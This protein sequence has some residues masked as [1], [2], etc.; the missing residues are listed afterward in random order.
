MANDL[1]ER[2]HLYDAFISYAHEDRATAIWLQDYLSNTWVPGK[3]RRRI[4]LDTSHLTATGTLSRELR[5]ILASSRYLVVCCSQA[6][7]ESSWVSREID[8]FIHGRTHSSRHD[9][10]GLL[11]CQ[12]GPATE[13]M[14]LPAAL[15]WVE[16]EINDQIILPDLRTVPNGQSHPTP[17]WSSEA[18]ALLAPLVGCRT[19]EE[20]LARRRKR[21]LF[22]TVC[23]IATLIT[24]VSVVIAIVRSDYFQVN[25]IISDSSVVRALQTP[26]PEP[27]L[28]VSAV[29]LAV[30]E[31]KAFRYIKQI[32][33]ETQK[34]L[35]LFDS[36]AT[37]VDVQRWS[38]A[39]ALVG[40]RLDGVEA[41]SYEWLVQK[42]AEHGRLDEAV[43]MAQ[44]VD[45]RVVKDRLLR[46]VSDA[47]IAT[48]NW[49]RALHLAGLIQDADSASAAFSALVQHLATA[50]KV[51]DGV[52]LLPKIRSPAPRIY[53]LASLGRATSSRGDVDGAARYFQE[54]SDLSR[55]VIDTP[56]NAATTNLF[57]AEHMD[58]AGRVVQPAT[59]ISVRFSHSA[60]VHYQSAIRAAMRIQDKHVKSSVLALVARSL[61]KGKHYD[62]AKRI[63]TKIDIS[64]REKIRKELID[65]AKHCDRELVRQSL[66]PRTKVAGEATA[67]QQI[68]KSPRAVE[69]ESDE[70]ERAITMAR[71]GN[72]RE[73]LALLDRAVS[74]AARLSWPRRSP[75]LA[76]IGQTMAKIGELRLARKIALE[77]S[78]EDRLR[79]YAAIL[80][81]YAIGD[82]SQQPRIER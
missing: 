53:A 68:Q 74:D 67:A 26:G 12:V 40:R 14:S 79:P 78:E 47:F 64:E 39:K 81:W 54:A 73:A 20:V 42:M 25:A 18:A 19:K 7:A 6:A 58:L 32:S 3:R 62:E 61:A 13:P 57:I 23:L 31:E 24:V 71:S 15:R 10:I 8:E 80:S 75:R 66:G 22:A 60:V 55:V 1:S 82:G 59:N 2:E 30:G 69:P 21:A 46:T 28:F 72:R 76:R 51:E 65:A 63:I 27:R 49:Q 36:V 56:V 48:N 41:T 38:E 37:L 45:V 70:L 17:R 9:N 35:C 4:F 52:K 33:S 34:S 43:D 5:E 77:C 29:A 44:Q 16:W 11:A 50:G